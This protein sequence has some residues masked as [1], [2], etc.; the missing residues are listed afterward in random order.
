MLET[1]EKTT[2]VGL[3]LIE[4]NEKLR[5]KVNNLQTLDISQYCSKQIYIEGELDCD[6]LHKMIGEVTDIKT[7]TNSVEMISSFQQSENEVFAICPVS[8]N[9]AWLMYRNSGEFRFLNRDGQY[10]ISVKKNASGISFIPR[11]GGFLVCNAYDK[12][13]L[14]VD[15]SGKSSVWMDTSPLETHFIGEAMNGN[16]LISLRDESER[17]P[18]RARGVFGWSHAKVTSSIA[19]STERTVLPY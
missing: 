15:M 11:D 9:E 1:F 16:I 3:D 5:A 13:I 17:E 10:M 7:G 4:Y 12:N 6:S 14:K 2:T 8:N 19:M 18:S